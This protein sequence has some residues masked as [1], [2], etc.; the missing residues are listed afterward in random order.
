VPIGTAIRIKTVHTGD[1][2]M[3]MLTVCF[4]AAFTL[5]FAVSADAAK[6]PRKSSGGSI[7]AQCR[8]KAKQMTTSREKQSTY[9]TRCIDSGGKL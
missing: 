5:S 6:K 3:K 7:A 8:A 2:Q 4:A 9:I 1:T